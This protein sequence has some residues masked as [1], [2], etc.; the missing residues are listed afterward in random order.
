MCLHRKIAPYQC[1]VFSITN[2]IKLYFSNFLL[3][4]IKIDYFTDS[5]T[6]QEL[7]ELSKYVSMLLERSHISVLNLN[8][9]QFSDSSALDQKQN[10]MDAIGV[11]YS[12]VIDAESLKTGFMKL[13]NRDTTL[14]ETI[15]ISYLKDYLPQIFQ[16]NN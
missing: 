16:S 8:D 11:P 6:S 14:S 4:R 15:H 2:S 1:S 9:C 3:V 5:S 12:L 10:E 13:R 7:R